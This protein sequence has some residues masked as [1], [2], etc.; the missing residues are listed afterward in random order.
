MAS[1]SSRQ[2]LIDYCL[3]ALGHPVIEI[4]VD[5]DQIEDRIDEA[6][7]YYRDYHYDAVESV[8]LKEQITAS[9]IQ[10]T[11][12]NAASFSIGEKI[13]GSSSGATTI[14]H[15]NVSANRFNVKNTA[16]TFTA[17]ETLVGASSGTTATLTSITLGNY[18]N[19]YITLDDSVLSV[20]RTLPLSSRSNSISFFDAKYQL[21]LNNIQSLTNT[22]IQYYTMLKM[23]INMINDLMTGQKPVRFNR[24]MNRL[25]IDLTWGD[26]GDLAIGDYVIIEAFR[27]LDPDSYTDV[28]NDG[29][30]KR[31]A[32]A[33]IKRQWGVNLKKF[34]GV[35]LPGGVTMNGQK[36]FDEAME[37][38]TILRQEVQNTYQ[39][40][41]DFFTG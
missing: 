8:Y 1:P 32:T 11:G 15:A 4:N 14:V 39:L 16:G 30:L 6:F 41:V 31:Y 33:L 25:Y 23:H 19:K 20:V 26:G 38:I 35:Q 18:D 34:E 40:P 17:G 10:I 3:R 13:T 37:E 28:Y 2:N 12:I 21:M 5:E 22:D 29:Y 24:H 36:I 27:T 7:Q 9:L